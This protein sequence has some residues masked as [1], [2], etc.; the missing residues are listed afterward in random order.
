MDK[1]NGKAWL[2]C[3]IV[4]LKDGNFVFSG[5][6]MNCSWA[7]SARLCSFRTTPSVVHK[8]LGLVAQAPVQIY[9]GLPGPSRAPAPAHL[10]PPP[11]DFDVFRREIEHLLLQVLQQQ[12]QGRPLLLREFYL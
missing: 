3:Q 5:S 10:A 4:L 9:H 8:D 2:S 7:T 6:C 12:Q 1:D 11:E